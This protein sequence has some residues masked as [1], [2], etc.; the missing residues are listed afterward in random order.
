MTGCDLKCYK[1]IYRKKTLG[2][3]SRLKAFDSQVLDN[4]GR[5]GTCC[6]MS[7]FNTKIRECCVVWKRVPVISSTSNKG[8]GNCDTNVQ[9]FICYSPHS[10]KV[11][12][13]SELVPSRGSIGPRHTELEN[14]WNSILPYSSISIESKRDQRHDEMDLSPE[15]FEADLHNAQSN[16]SDTKQPNHIKALELSHDIVTKITHHFS[17]DSSCDERHRHDS[18]PDDPLDIGSGTYHS[19]NHKSFTIFDHAHSQHLDLGPT[20]K[21]IVLHPVSDCPDGL[22]PVHLRPITPSHHEAQLEQYTIA[23]T[24]AAECSVLH[25]DCGARERLAS[26]GSR[27]RTHAPASPCP[28]GIQAELFF[29]VRQRRFWPAAE[30]AWGGA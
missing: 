17:C 4:F 12:G 14:E 5:S 18:D 13:H 9:S 22:S 11:G 24:A 7:I 28:A 1:S 27:A 2:D 21:H 20:D 6:T 16:S 3:K 23:A 29:H 8:R 10:N 26:S 15:D 30:A 19:N 25:H